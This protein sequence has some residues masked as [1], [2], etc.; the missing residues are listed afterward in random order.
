MKNVKRGFFKGVSGSS[1][2]SNE[3]KS[4]ISYV[5]GILTQNVLGT[6]NK[7]LPVMSVGDNSY[8]TGYNY[9][10]QKLSPTVQTKQPFGAYP[11]RGIQGGPRIVSK[12]LTYDKLLAM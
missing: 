1:R 6:P 12:F 5:P 7:V 9:N 2:L 10:Q 3:I 4:P 8:S 11:L